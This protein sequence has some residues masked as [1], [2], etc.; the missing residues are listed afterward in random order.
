MLISLAEP[1]ASFDQ[2]E[3]SYVG[4][5]ANKTDEK[6]PAQRCSK[7]SMVSQL[8]LPPIVQE[9]IAT[10]IIPVTTGLDEGYVCNNIGRYSGS[11]CL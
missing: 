6:K 7:V 1:G 3:A 9:V 5:A 2:E 10:A 11:P 4:A 8:E